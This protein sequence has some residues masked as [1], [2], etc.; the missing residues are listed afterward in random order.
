ML[1]TPGRARLA[2]EITGGDGS[3]DVP[4][5]H[6]GV[7][8]PR[9]WR[10]VIEPPSPPHRCVAYD[11]RGFGETTYEREDG[12]SRVAPAVA[13]LDAAGVERP[14]VVAS[15]LDGQTAGVRHT[16]GPPPS[17]RRGRAASGPGT[18]QPI[19]P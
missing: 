6:A 13:V 16:P 4:L 18:E 5:I 7:N 3:A 10:H 8:D 1:A 2:Y 12:W 11:V 14:V 19:Y 9:S 17:R 15:S